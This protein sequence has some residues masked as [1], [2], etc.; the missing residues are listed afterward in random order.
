[1]KVPFLD[2]IAPYEELKAELDEAYFRFMRSAWYILGKEVEAFE[3]EFAN[4]CGAK[5]CV[6][7]GNGLEALHLILRAYGI[8]KGDEVIVPSNTYIATWLAVSYADAVP[9]PVE[10]DSKTFNLDPN[11]IEAAITPRT[12]A[13]MPVHLYG[14]PAD[15]DSI[16]KIAQKHGLKVI[17]D[18]AQAQGARY[19]GRRTGSLGDAAGNSFYPGKNLGAFGD[20]GAVTTNDDA[21][22]EK[23]RVLRNYGSKKKYYNEVKGY[24]S[25][26]DELQAAFLRVRLKKMDE[27][28][29]RRCAVAENYLQGLRGA[30]DL[31][32]PFVPA[33]SEPAWHLFVVRHPE[34]DLLQQ[35]LT[36]AEIGTLIHYPVPPHLSGAYADAK[37]KRGNFPIAESMADAVLSLPMGPHLPS[38]QVEQVIGRIVECA[39]NTFA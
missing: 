35:K 18:N 26:L 33:W 23:V 24:N 4:Y 10:P 28:N 27:W 12:K 7:V 8:G 15:M 31:T 5:H 19:K 36:E 32:L 25:R 38:Q 3:Q 22:A 29:G 2:F 39:K 13:V 16:L 11:R 1:M 17:E 37:W 21:L 14:Q 6:G 30:A 20:A 34:R 9:V